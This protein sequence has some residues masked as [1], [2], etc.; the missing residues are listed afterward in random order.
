MQEIYIV[1]EQT[2]VGRWLMERRI[3]GDWLSLSSLLSQLSRLYG[4]A[5]VASSGSKTG[6]GSGI[7]LSVSDSSLPTDS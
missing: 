4:S 5:Y 2:D 3:T 1:K 7:P 6:R